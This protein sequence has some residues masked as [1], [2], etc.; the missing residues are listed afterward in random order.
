MK[1]RSDV[2]QHFI[3]VYNTSSSVR[4]GKRRQESEDA[5]M[6]VAVEIE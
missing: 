4:I 6:E 3:Y 1:M 5:C 2:E